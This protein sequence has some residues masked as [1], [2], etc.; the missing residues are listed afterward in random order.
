MKRVLII[1]A[2]LF[3][4]FSLMAQSKLKQTA[5]PVY[6][7]SQVRPEG[8]STKVKVDSIER[9]EKKVVSVKLN[10][11]E[12]TLT[13]T[14]Y[15]MSIDR[16]NDDLNSIRD[17]SVLKFE[18]VSMGRR[19]DGITKEINTIRKNTRGR[20]SVFNIKNLYLYQSF[21]SNLNDEN[22]GYEARAARIYQR[23]YDAK[24]SLK[25]ALSDSVFRVMF[26][27]DSLKKTFNT[28]LLRLEKKYNRTDSTVK[29][30]IDTIN[31]LKMEIA[32]NA[33]NLS[34]MLNMMEVRLDK[35]DKQLFGNELNYLWDKAEK[36]AKSSEKSIA[37]RTKLDNEKNA[38]DYYLSRTSGE[39]EFVVIL[40]VLLFFWLFIN[41]KMLKS[42]RKPAGASGFLNLKYMKSS[43]ALSVLVLVISL[44]PLFDAYAPTSYIAIEYFI[45]IVIT[46][47]IFSRD[48]RNTF[49]LYWIAL[50]LLFTANILAFLF[51]EPKFSSRLWMLVL[52]TGIIIISFLF[53]WNL[54]KSR[55]FYKW[56]KAAAITAIILSLAAIVCNLLGRF[57]LSGIFGVSAIFAIIQ[58]VVLAVFAKIIIEIILLQLQSRRIKKGIASSFDSSVI[59]EKLK[60]PVGIITLFLWLIMLTSNLNIYHSVTNGVTEFLTSTR[61]IGSISFKLISVIWFFVIIWFAHILQRL[62]S[63]L[64]GETG[65]DNEDTSSVAKQ[66]HSRLL[67]TRLLVLIGGY[68]IAIAASGLPLDKLTI[69]LG[70]LGVGIGM[71]LQ[72]VVNNFVS[73]I[74]LIFDG[75][76]RIGDE[77]EVSGQ[78]GRVKE[79]GLR[80]ST[81]TT[82]D[83]ADVII[84]NGNIL[85]QN[86]VN[87]TFT[88]D[89]KRVTISFTLSG[90]ELDAN[91]INEVINDTIKNIPDVIPVKKPVI[92]YTKVT[93]SSCGLNVRFWSIIKSSEH[94][95]SEAMPQLSAAFATKS[96]HFE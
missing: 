12:D 3:I 87:W 41:R 42:I 44:M 33:V 31:V 16:V 6:Q 30:N 49:L 2:F 20:S 54:E 46:T 88:Q 57:S 51:I 17:S 80:A 76:L 94:T 82:A 61:T 55:V 8:D 66:Q 85:S 39:R 10:I 29:A 72:N 74:I 78:S 56:I 95:K 7:Q 35:A 36:A 63:F 23:V 77:I 27:D 73:G 37:G 18:V 60:I 9:S 86:I 24:L 25:S 93:P 14:D 4:G 83:G 64:F 34:N 52:Q 5:A 81:L 58:A 79:L 19:V 15:M 69:I 70:A 75:T 38:I 96:I 26:A 65:I 43:P 91:I 40:G 71:G 62:I 67:I 21:I 47:I 68:L 1:P 11:A 45:L 84:P 28:K 53:M 13:P 59:E 48:E 32:D 50:I 22:D 92:L 89:Q 90:K